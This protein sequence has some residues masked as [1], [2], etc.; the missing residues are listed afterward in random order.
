MLSS[1]SAL[2][3][4]PALGSPLILVISITSFHFFH[5]GQ[6]L[7]ASDL[8]LKTFASFL[9]LS[10]FRKSSVHSLIDD[11]SVLRPCLFLV[12]INRHAQ[13]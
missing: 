8:Y 13:K 6:P 4:L 12:A 7:P 10:A 5:I 11:M 3:Q 1:S 2:D 9:V